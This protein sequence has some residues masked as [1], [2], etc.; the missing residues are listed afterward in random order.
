MNGWAGE[1]GYPARRGESQY[2]RRATE[3]L[4]FIL[5]I[6]EDPDARL[7]VERGGE[8]QEIVVDLIWDTGARV[9]PTIIDTATASG[10]G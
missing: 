6:K 5:S 8:V 2:L 7:L 3:L 1:A 4:L 10:Q 9:T